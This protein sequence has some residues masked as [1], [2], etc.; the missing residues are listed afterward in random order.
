MT[1]YLISG[2]DNLDLTK[3]K[4]H[5]YQSLLPSM[6]TWLS[7]VP[8]HR[9]FV[10]YGSTRSS[11]NIIPRDVLLSYGCVA[12]HTHH[13][14]VCYNSTMFQFTALISNCHDEGHIGTNGFGNHECCKYDHAMNHAMNQDQDWVYI[15]DD[16]MF[17]DIR[18][19]LKF[20][21]TQNP[22]RD[23]VILSSDDQFPYNY[24]WAKGIAKYNYFIPQ[25]FYYTVMS[26]AA[27]HTMRSAIQRK[28]LSKVCNVTNMAY[29]TAVGLLGFYHDVT[30]L[31][32][33]EQTLQV[34]LDWNPSE[35][36]ARISEA[37]SDKNAMIFY[38]NVKNHMCTKPENRNCMALYNS[39]QGHIDDSHW[40]PHFST[41]PAKKID[42]KSKKV[43]S[44]LP[45]V[46][47]QSPQW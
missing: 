44:E 28:T 5:L 24:H 7:S 42:V 36:D 13:E 30:F 2:F 17:I 45:I 29:D 9:R 3:N 22:R 21:D 31:R 6:R 10:I 20:L 1:Y 37:V 26:N 40:T 4:N 43:V 19:M 33:C 38:H 41:A 15:G 16:D 46:D 35:F 8:Y 18:R 32:M 11:D 27:V 39:L 25:G 12:T 47:D 14:L 34:S 23:R